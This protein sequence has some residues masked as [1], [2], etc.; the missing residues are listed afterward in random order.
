MPARLIYIKDEDT[1]ELWTVNVQPYGKVDTFE[2]RHG[3]GYTQ[4][5]S[6]YRAIQAALR[7]FVPRGIDAELWELELANTGK[8]PRRAVRLLLR[9]YGAG[10]HLAGRAGSAVYGALQ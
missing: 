7:Y 4:I 6:S 5:S 8:A 2:A 3:M 9:R 10:Q 1:G